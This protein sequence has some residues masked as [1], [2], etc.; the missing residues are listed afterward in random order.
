[1]A[2]RIALS[3]IDTL[4]DSD[5]PHLTADVADTL[6]SAGQDAAA[7]IP[8]IAPLVQAL[9]VVGNI[10]NYIFTK[11]VLRFLMALRDVDEEARKAFVGD[12]HASA[13]ERQRVGETLM[14]LLERLDDV[15]KAD[16]AGRFFKEYVSRRIDLDTFR[17]LGGALDRVATYHFKWLRALYADSHPADSVPPE[18]LQEFANAGLVSIYLSQAYGDAG[19]RYDRNSLGELFVHLAFAP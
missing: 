17:R 7:S 10:S 11:K 1:M 15:S 12:L 16:V 13:D 4:A 19:G 14:L 8:V 2:D 3:L 18:A 9:R 6:L 5:L